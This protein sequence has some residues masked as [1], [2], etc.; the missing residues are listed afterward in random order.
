MPLIG[1]R[2][3]AQLADT[4]A[5]LSLALSKDE[6][7]AIEQAVPKDAAAGERYGLAQM[8]QLDSELPA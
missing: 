1:A 3:R 6:L 7:E 5:G 2:N 8:K 4:L